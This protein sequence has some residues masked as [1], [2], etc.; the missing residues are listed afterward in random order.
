MK[1]YLKGLLLWEVIETNMETSMPENP[2]LNHLKIYK[3]HLSKK[4]RALSTLHT[5]IDE[6]IF[7]RIM[8]CET[9]KQVWDKLKVEFQG[10]DKTR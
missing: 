3:E 5:V 8:A 1:A 7:I 6:T 9:T 10:N 4:F 2:T